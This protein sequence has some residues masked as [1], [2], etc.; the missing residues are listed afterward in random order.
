MKWR[1]NCKT[2]F[3][4]KSAHCWK[5]TGCKSYSYCCYLC[6]SCFSATIAFLDLCLWLLTSFSLFMRFPDFY[7][8]NYNRDGQDVEVQIFSHHLPICCL[9]IQGT[10]V[11]N[12]WRV[13]SF[14]ISG[15]CVLIPTHDFAS[16]GRDVQRRLTSYSSAISTF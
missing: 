5:R 15:D 14:Q 16:C 9:G 11:S 7:S 2:A 1:R 6:F 3:C 8:C 4:T 12:I 10:I 13:A